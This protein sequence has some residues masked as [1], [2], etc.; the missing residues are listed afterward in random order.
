MNEKDRP[1]DRLAGNVRARCRGPLAAAQ[2]QDAE[3][4]NVAPQ[5][6]FRQVV[7]LLFRKSSVDRPGQ[8][9]A[10]APIRFAQV[11]AQNAFRA[12]K[13]VL[14]LLCEKFRHKNDVVVADML[15][16]TRLLP[17]VIL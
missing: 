1:P 2:Q 15:A 7:L 17:V 3:V 10:A 9:D 16:G 13:D 11:C 14:H 4:F 12:A 8:A 5:K 6:R